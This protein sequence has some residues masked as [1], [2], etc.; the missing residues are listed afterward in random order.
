MSLSE[1]GH[2][3]ADKH[4]PSV[5]RITSRPAKA[6]PVF[7]ALALPITQD[8]TTRIVEAVLKTLWF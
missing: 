1:I 3:P 4:P 6:T 7:I 8:S 5:P 2:S